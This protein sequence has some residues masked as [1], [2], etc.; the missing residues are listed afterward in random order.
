M[1]THI[2]D[3]NEINALIDAASRVREHMKRLC[4]HCRAPYEDHG[5]FTNGCPAP[6][7]TKFAVMG[8]EACTS[9]GSFDGGQECGKECVA[10]TPFCAEHM[11]EAL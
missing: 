5:N 3:G 11:T 8:C 2:V 4:K 9:Y 1:S 10:G 6:A 7:H